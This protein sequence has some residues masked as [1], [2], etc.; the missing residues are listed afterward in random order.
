MMKVNDRLPAEVPHIPLNSFDIPCSGH[1]LHAEGLEHFSGPHWP[2][3]TK[4]LLAQNRKSGK[5]SSPRS[6]L[7]SSRCPG[8][9]QELWTEIPTVCRGN[10]KTSPLNASLWV[11]TSPSPLLHGSGWRFSRRRGNRDEHLNFSSQ[12]RLSNR[13]RNALV[14]SVGMFTRL[15]ALASSDAEKK[16]ATLLLEGVI[17]YV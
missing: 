13:S 16:V 11:L 5:W 17:W 6:D 7:I 12:S 14:F 10:I 1:L 3:F 2:S 9:H 8:F 4:S 15:T